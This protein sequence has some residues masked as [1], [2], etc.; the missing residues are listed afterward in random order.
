MNNIL[1]QRVI[2]LIAISYA[3]SYDILWAYYEKYGD[4]EKILKLL[5]T[6]ELLN[7]Q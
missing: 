3:I 7:E 6:N 1:R 5:E 4:I 2:R